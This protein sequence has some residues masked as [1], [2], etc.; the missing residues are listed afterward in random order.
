MIHLR[1]RVQF[2]TGGN[3][4]VAVRQQPISIRARDL[5]IFVSS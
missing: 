1:G 3:Y 5:L 4:A 2:P